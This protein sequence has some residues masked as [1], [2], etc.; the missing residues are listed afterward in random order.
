MLRRWKRKNDWNNQTWKS[1]KIHLLTKRD[2]NFNQLEFG[3]ESNTKLIR[4]YFMI[5]KMWSTVK[6]GAFWYGYVVSRY[7]MVLLKAQGIKFMLT[8]IL[9]I[10]ISSWASTGMDRWHQIT[11]RR[12]CCDA[13]GFIRPQNVSLENRF[14]ILDEI[15]KKASW[16]MDGWLGTN[17]YWW[18]V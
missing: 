10:V 5:P 14:M 4:S 13:L 1:E 12:G 7:H 6:S 2:W 8:T 11:H 16:T 18:R 9:F 3:V 17:D 15:E